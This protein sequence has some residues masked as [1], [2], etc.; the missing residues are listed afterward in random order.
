MKDILVIP[1][2]HGR[3]FWA[4]AIEKYPDAEVIFLGDY[5]DPYPV[6]KITPE[7]AIANFKRIL[8]YAKTHSNCQLLFGNHDL[9]Y[10]CNFGEACRLDYNNA[11]EIHYLLIDN[12]PMFQLAVLRQF[13]DKKVVFSHAPILT[14]WVEEVGETTDVNL[15]VRRLNSVIGVV[16]ANPWTV[17]DYIG[18]MS[19]YRGGYD[20]VGS[21]VW[22]DVAEIKD[23]LL[24]TADYFVFGHTQQLKGPIIT[25]KWACLDCRKAFLIAPDLSITAIV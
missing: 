2:V 7:E 11:A 3:T 22:A 6:E 16:C 19:I 5:L 17:E 14:D 9:H 8:C 4:D 12:L 13:N 18:Q 21:P 20:N 15:L 23:N 10:L 25:P 1:D 24:P